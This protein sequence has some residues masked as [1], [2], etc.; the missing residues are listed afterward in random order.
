MD[1]A[2][3]TELVTLNASKAHLPIIIFSA[4]SQLSTHFF[5]KFQI[6]YRSSFLRIH[7]F[8]NINCLLLDDYPLSHYY[9]KCH[10]CKHIHIQM[11]SI[12]ANPPEYVALI[13]KNAHIIAMLIIMS[14]VLSFFSAMSH[15][16][17]SSPSHAKSS[18]LSF[19]INRYDHYRCDDGYSKQYPA[20][21]IFTEN[22]PALF[23]LPANCSTSYSAE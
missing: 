20:R 2:P 4:S 21:N 19:L 17:S 5:L 6:I 23:I 22:A 8:G 13:R 12:I 15:I 10:N 14:T 3:H 18:L 16:D 11:F 9:Q 1:S 7:Y